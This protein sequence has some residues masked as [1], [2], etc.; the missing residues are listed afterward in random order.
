MFRL[1]IDVATRPMLPPLTDTTISPRERRDLGLRLP[2]LFTHQRLPM[3]LQELSV[4]V[5]EDGNDGAH[6]GTLT[7]ADAD[8]LLD[9]AIAL[10]EGIFTEPE[11]IKAA[12]A[13]R[14]QRRKP[15]PTS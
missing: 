4:A 12:K 1:A 15:P 14:E 10:L 5:R 3:S 6:Q 7:E 13:R 2:W 8:D 11:R 9:F